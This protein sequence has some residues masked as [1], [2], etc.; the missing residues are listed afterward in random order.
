[1]EIDKVYVYLKLK[2]RSN[3]KCK[4]MKV[5]KEGKKVVPSLKKTAKKAIKE[6]K[7]SAKV[8]N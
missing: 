8:F 1:M 4:K 3:M 2:G 7:K 5:L 6:T